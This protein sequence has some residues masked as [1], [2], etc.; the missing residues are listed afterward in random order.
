MSNLL[1]TSGGLLVHT[2]SIMK[3]LDEKKIDVDTAKA[4]ASLIKQSNNLLRYELD[5]RKFD[6]KIE[7]SNNKKSEPLS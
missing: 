1:T 3:K 4:Q 5:I 6:Y 2:A 7:E